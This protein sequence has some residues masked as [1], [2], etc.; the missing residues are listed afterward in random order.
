MLTQIRSIQDVID[1]GLCSGCG[2]CAYAC[3]HGAVRM[4]NVPSVGTRPQIDAHRCESD[5]LSGECLSICPGAGVDATLAKDHNTL[6]GTKDD[7]GPVFEI[8]EG[9]ATDPD[10][11]FRAS[12]GGLLT[13]LSSYCLE[14]EGMGFVLHTGK[15]P[16]TPWLNTTVQSKTRAE[17]LD[18]AGSRYAPSSPCD[19]LESI[20]QSPVPCVFIGKPCDVAAVAA[21]RQTRHKLD[22]NLGLVLTFFCAGTPSTNGTL[23]LMNGMGADPK[24]VTNVR[25][26]GRGWPGAFVVDGDQGNYPQSMSYQESWQKLTEHRPLRC[27]LCPDGMGQLADISCGDAWEKYDATQPN[28]G[29][30]IVI[31]RT[32]R[33]K[34]ILRRAMEAN[35]VTLLS[36]NRAAV[37]SAQ[38]N[39][40]GRRK[41]LFG[42]SLALR[43]LLIPTPRFRGFQLLNS[44]CKLPL[45]RQLRSIAGTFRRALQRR[46]WKRNGCEEYRRESPLK[47]RCE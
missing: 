4:V 27:N 45:S 31:V 29:M 17:L 24:T 14:R 10:I 19:G 47:T 35:Y 12:S 5:C 26:R 11:R 44:W 23:E 2:A 3:S 32:S 20:E 18:R 39:L 41:E 16:A 9:Y 1:W 25:Y 38:Q 43:L 36:A 37:L 28:P 33:G 6:P 22:K 21:L 15:S 46:W 40:M 7:L 13:A 34:E 42:R 30:S 8:W